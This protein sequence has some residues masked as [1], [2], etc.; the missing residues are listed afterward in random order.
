MEYLPECPLLKQ[1]C[2]LADPVEYNDTAKDCVNQW[3]GLV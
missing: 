1:V 2:S 3:I